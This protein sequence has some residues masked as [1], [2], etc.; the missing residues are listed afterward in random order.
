MK[1]NR[2]DCAVSTNQ[3]LIN[4]YDIND[5]YN[6]PRI[7]ASSSFSKFKIRTSGIFSDFNSLFYSKN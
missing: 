5:I 1:N 3:S 2:F 7:G 6:L 4:K